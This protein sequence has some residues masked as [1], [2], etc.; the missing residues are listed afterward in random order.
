MVF[1][2]LTPTQVREA[3][4]PFATPS[5]SSADSTGRSQSKVIANL[6]RHLRVEE[7]VQQELLTWLRRGLTQVLAGASLEDGD[8]W[9]R[10][11]DAAHDSASLGEVIAELLHE[12]RTR[13]AARSVVDRIHAVLRDV[14]DQENEA[15]AVATR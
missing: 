7:E 8:S 5:T 3:I 14:V 13:G 15:M 9:A 4:A 12:L 2:A 1:N 10:R 6:E 11:V